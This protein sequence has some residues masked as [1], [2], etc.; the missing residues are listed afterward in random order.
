MVG[1]VAVSCKK[2]A[3]IPTTQDVVFKATPTASG[4]FKDGQPGECVNPMA[5]YAL[6]DIDGI[7]HTV[8]VFYLA[9]VIYTNTLKLDPGMHTISSFI[10]Q[11][12]NGTPGDFTDDVM[13]QARY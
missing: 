13:V 10:L 9:G 7:T 8:D 1:M 2:P 4:N 12:D 11:N 6:I 3:D 5:H